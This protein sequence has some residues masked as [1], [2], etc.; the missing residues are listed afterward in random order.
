MAAEAPPSSRSTINI[1]FYESSPKQG[2]G[3]ALYLATIC[4][5]VFYLVW[6]YIPGGLEAIGIYYV[7]NRTWAIIVPLWITL[8]IP[9]TI[10]T[11]V[12][13]NLHKTPNFESNYTYT[14]EV[15]NVMDIATVDL[16]KLTADDDIPELQDVPLHLVNATLWSNN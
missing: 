11:F 15:A 7:P 9:Y 13:H 6:T 16:N 4:F 5:F 12:G 14:D 10:I 3:F 8:L 1:Q 2:Y